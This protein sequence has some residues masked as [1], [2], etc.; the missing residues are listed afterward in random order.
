MVK[1]TRYFTCKET[2]VMLGLLTSDHFSQRC[3]LGGSYVKMDI[4]KLTVPLN[5]GRF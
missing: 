3:F 1:E 2:E 5:S 4:L